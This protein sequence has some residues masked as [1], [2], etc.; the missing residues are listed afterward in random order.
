MLA[1]HPG[2]P[3]CDPT[4]ARGKAI[5]M[6]L[7]HKKI[8]LQVNP[9]LWPEVGLAQPHCCFCNRGPGQEGASVH[10]ARAEVG[11][12]GP[13]ECSIQIQAPPSVGRFPPLPVLQLALARFTTSFRITPLCSLTGAI[14]GVCGGFTP[15][16]SCLL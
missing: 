10:Q 5:L 8:K 11:E 16:S 1:G 14:K 4:T 7:G 12:L 13:W 3:Q 15:F 6:Q 2:Q 9:A